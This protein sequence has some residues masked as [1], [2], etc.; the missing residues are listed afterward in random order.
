[1]RANSVRLM[2][3]VM[4]VVIMTAL[5]GVAGAATDEVPHDAAYRRARE[6]M[7]DLLASEK[8]DKVEIATA[9]FD[10]AMALIYT[11]VDGY[12]ARAIPA[13]GGVETARKF[14]V[15]ILEGLNDH[16]IHYADEGGYD[17]VGN[18]RLL[19][20]NQEDAEDLGEL[21]AEVATLIRSAHGGVG[22]D[23]RRAARKIFEGMLPV[24]GT[25]QPLVRQYLTRLRTMS[26]AERRA[27]LEY[28]LE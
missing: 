16:T 19:I 10:K 4:V 28:A 18:R 25:G 26:K 14:G 6:Q 15:A 11:A 23:V 17:L 8:F 2:V 3:V 5:P 9:S 7:A 13:L 21:L 22:V 27:L 1:M 24:A 12:L 20:S